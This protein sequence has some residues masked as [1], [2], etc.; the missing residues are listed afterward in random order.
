ML[1]CGIVFWMLP[2]SSQNKFQKVS[3]LFPW[4]G[5]ASARCPNCLRQI[6][7]R[8]QAIIKRPSKEY[9]YDENSAHDNDYGDDD[10]KDSDNDCEYE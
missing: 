10:D 6:S 8:H 2:K 3:K 5:K 4:I 1:L 9:A 7:K